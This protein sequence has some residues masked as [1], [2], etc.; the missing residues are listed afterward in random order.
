MDDKII[1]GQKVK[2][3]R[4]QHSGMI[5]Q[6]IIKITKNYDRSWVEK[7]NRALCAKIF[8]NVEEGTQRGVNELSI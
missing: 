7:S 6:I 3:L 1:E 5:F 4:S 2:K 8:R